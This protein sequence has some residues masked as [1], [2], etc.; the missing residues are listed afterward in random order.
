MTPGPE[1]A[2]RSPG[3]PIMTAQE[4]QAL[5]NVSRETLARLERYVATLKKWNRAI[6]LVSRRSLDDVWRRHILDSAQLLA[7]APT[8]A[9]VW[10]DLG[11]GAGLPGLVLAIMGAGEVHLVES[12]ARKCAF[13]A[14]AA[15]AADTMVKIHQC[16]IEVL[17]RR[18][19]KPPRVDVVTARALTGIDDLIDLTVLLTTQHTV[20]LFMRGQDVE[21]E[22][23]KLSKLGKLT[24]ESLASRTNPSSVVLR[25]RG[26]GLDQV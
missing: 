5:T 12:D 17:W 3:P 19:G 14:E 23:T 7:H 15:R 18:G 26:I 25:I 22:L 10:L 24:I 4:F 1:T 2:R 21:N 6:N 20:C 11:S 13:L 16:R 9:E 8:D